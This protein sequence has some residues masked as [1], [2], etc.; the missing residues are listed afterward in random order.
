MGRNNR[1]VSQ[2]QRLDVQNQ[3]VD[4]LILFW[5]FLGIGSVTLPDSLLGVCHPWYLLPSG[6]IAQ[7]PVLVITWCSPN[8]SMSKLPSSNEDTDHIE[9]R[10]HLNLV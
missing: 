5:N 4:G 2:F 9:F 6:S 1:R 8:V 7:T 10:A 3:G